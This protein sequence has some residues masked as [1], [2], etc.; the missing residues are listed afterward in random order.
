LCSQQSRTSN[1][2][3]LV[4]ITSLPVDTYP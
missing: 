4:E 1:Y 2:A 3:L